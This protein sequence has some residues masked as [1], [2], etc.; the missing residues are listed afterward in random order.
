M[1]KSLMLVSGVIGVFYTAYLYNPWSVEYFIVESM[2]FS[3]L[4]VLTQ[5]INSE[6]RNSKKRSVKRG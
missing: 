5:Q 4:F 2:I 6:K 1:I 3:Y